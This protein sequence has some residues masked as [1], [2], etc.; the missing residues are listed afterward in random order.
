MYSDGQPLFHGEEKNG[1][2][3]TVNAIELL[4][5]RCSQP[6]LSGQAP[7]ENELQVLFQAAVRAP[8][9]AYLRP[10]RFITVQGTERD[11]LGELFVRAG[12]S[13]G[14][15]TEQQRLKLLSMPQRAPMIVIAVAKI[16]EH[17][18]VPPVEQIL[19]T[20]MALNQ[21]QLAAQALG[22]GSILRTGEMAYSPVVKA[23]LGLAKQ[24]H[25]VGFLYLGQVQGK[26]KKMQAIDWNAY[27]EPLSRV[28]SF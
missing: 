2:E 5:Q 11:K 12:E 22:Y 24:D 7:D 16:I 14:N 8:D 3:K 20:G 1:D 19:A 15:L 10:W 27:V 13:E 26:G 4:R 9:H 6:M 23:G 25:I 28:L 18:K 21:F 17:E